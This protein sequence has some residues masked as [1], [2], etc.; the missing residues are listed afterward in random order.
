MPALSAIKSELLAE[1]AGDLRYAPRLAARRHADRA[2]ALAG[3]ID[4]DAWY[5]EDWLVF[6]V[7][8]YRPE[9]AGESLIVGAAVLADLSALVE[10]L[11]ERL[12]ESLD[13]YPGAVRQAE[14]ESRWGVSPRTIDRARRAGLVARRARDARGKPVLVFTPEAV[15]AY[16]ARDPRRT[17]PPSRPRRMTQTERTWVLR[18][19]ASYGARLGWGRMKIAQ[20]LAARSGRSAEAIR[21]MLAS[22]GVGPDTPDRLGDRNGRLVVRAE[23]LGIGAAEVAQRLQRPTRSVLRAVTATRCSHGQR[24]TEALDGW[25][26]STLDPPGSHGLPGWKPTGEVG[27]LLARA[28]GASPVEAA[29]ERAML[30]WRRAL[31]VGA[32]ELFRVGDRSG[33]AD[34]ASFRLRVASRVVAVL[35]MAELPVIV[36]TV[37]DRLGA[38]VESLGHTRASALL[39]RCLEE[40]GRDAA[41][42]AL[43][44]QGHAPRGRL[45]ARV[46]VSA[47]RAAGGSAHLVPKPGRATPAFEYAARVTEWRLGID[48]WQHELEPHAAV[49]WAVE[50]GGGDG[51]GESGLL[52][53][54]FVLGGVEPGA[55]VPDG[56]LAGIADDLSLPRTV[57]G[58]RIQAE[59]RASVVAW[60]SRA[61]SRGP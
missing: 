29:W 32:A 30:D 59:V 26:G 18:R 12:A 34:Q 53:R 55:V 42:M 45:A 25:F 5:P 7:T 17:T 13:A 36:R 31:V 4:P 51:G 48:P 28:R 11:T 33:T 1:L 6:R 60:R 23:R 54:R 20:R 15:E 52:S 16:E 47:N 3:E 10:R 46:T 14:L 8:G 57:V 41:R 19:A 37:E 40:A 49:L 2:E 50:N 35:A 56:T 38:P 22:E 21:A 58:R 44:T 39:A 24:W 27:H 61:G 9:D 43:G